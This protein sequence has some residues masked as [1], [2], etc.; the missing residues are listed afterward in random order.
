MIEGFFLPAREQAR[1]AAAAHRLTAGSRRR[2]YLA[3]MIASAINGIPGP[4][5]FADVRRAAKPGW[6][7]AQRHQQKKE[8]IKSNGSLE[9]LRLN[10]F[11]LQE[12]FDRFVVELV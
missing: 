10:T 8:G 5:R 2:V 6:A 7:P 3:F 9:Q 1:G 4:N 12:L 11:F